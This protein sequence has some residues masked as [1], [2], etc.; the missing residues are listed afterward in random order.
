MS[1]TIIVAGM[2]L[3]GTIV[4]SYFIQSKSIAV[5]GEKI[6]NLEKKVEKH[7]EIVERTYKVEASVKSAHKRLDDM[8]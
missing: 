4:G 8:Q 2:S 5:L 6:S 7:N 1:D 3:V